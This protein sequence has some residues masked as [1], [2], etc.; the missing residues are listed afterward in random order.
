VFC[1]SPFL[2]FAWLA[3]LVLVA[4]SQPPAD[5]YA[6]ALAAARGAKD[7]MLR[8]ASDSPVPRDKRQI[9]LPLPYFAGDPAYRVPASLAPDPQTGGVLQMLTSTG[10]QRPT[11]MMGVLQFVLHGQPLKL[12]AFAEEGS[13]GQRLFVPFMDET[14]GHE[15]YAAGRYL[16]LDRTATGIYVIDFNAAYNPYCAY[17]PTYDCPVPPRENRL[18]VAIR[19]G[20]KAPRR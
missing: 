9:L 8:T 5:D 19:A 2:F 6:Q 3:L 11:Q 10:Q 4:C 18:P 7:E 12:E 16:D 1:R 17:N 13:N 14:T 20:E 15:T